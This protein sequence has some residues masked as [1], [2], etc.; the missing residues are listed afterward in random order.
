MSPVHAH[1]TLQGVFFQQSITL[2]HGLPTP[3]LW[4]LGKMIAQLSAGWLC[5]ILFEEAGRNRRNLRRNYETMYASTV[6]QPNSGAYPYVV[7]SIVLVQRALAGRRSSLSRILY[8][9]YRVGALAEPSRP[10][11]RSSRPARAP[12]A[13]A[14]L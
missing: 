3:S 12:C 2:V 7:V 10:V 14:G 6:Q 5:C 4:P 8:C 9:L 11:G 13:R 1:R